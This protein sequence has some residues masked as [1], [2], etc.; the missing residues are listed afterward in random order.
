MLRVLFVF[1]VFFGVIALLTRTPRMRIA[2]YSLLGLLV[3]YAIL[4]ATGLID[5]WAPDRMGGAAIYAL[6]ILA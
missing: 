5:A 2:F 4:K 1:L 3:V 6:P